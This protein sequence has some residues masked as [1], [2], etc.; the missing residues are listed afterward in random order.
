MKTNRYLDLKGATCASCAYTIERTGR[1]LDGVED[2]HVDAA[3]AKVEV[4]FSEHEADKQRE[5]L[6]K[7]QKVIQLL[8]YDADITE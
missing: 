4:T 6:E 8:G 7:I 2:V 5:V 1:K 3:D